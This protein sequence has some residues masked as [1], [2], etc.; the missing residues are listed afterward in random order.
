MTLAK[1]GVIITW[2]SSGICWAIAMRFASEG[3]KGGLL[4][5]RGQ[6]LEQLA[7]E[8]EKAGGTAAIA[9]AD[10]ANRAETVAAIHSLRDQLGPVDLLI[11]NAGLGKPSYADQSNIDEVEAMFKVNTLGVVYCI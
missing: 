7:T 6:N 10:L 9:P 5:R 11:A 8:I 3:A 2:A 4:G 1:K